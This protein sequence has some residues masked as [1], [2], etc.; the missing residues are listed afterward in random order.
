MVP[1]LTG[2][3][4]KLC[5]LNEYNFQQSSSSPLKLAYE[6]NCSII[7]LHQLLLLSKQNNSGDMTKLMSRYIGKNRSGYECSMVGPTLYSE[8]PPTEGLKEGVAVGEEVGPD[9]G[10]LV[11]AGLYSQPQ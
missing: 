8:T 7:D 4:I 2:I 6:Y 11:R 5:N 9:D 10:V 1:D 3:C